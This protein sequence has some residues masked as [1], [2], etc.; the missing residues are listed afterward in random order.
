VILSKLFLPEERM[1]R[2]KRNEEKKA[3]KKRRK[4]SKRQFGTV[5]AKKKV[6]ILAYEHAPK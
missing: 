3:G 4:R 5:L 1:C 6:Q 2:V